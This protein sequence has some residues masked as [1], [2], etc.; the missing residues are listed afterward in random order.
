MRRKLLATAYPP[1]QKRDKSQVVSPGIDAAS[2]VGEA[3]E[4]GGM[5]REELTAGV[6]AGGGRAKAGEDASKAGQGT[7][8][9]ATGANAGAGGISAGKGRS[10]R[11]GGLEDLAGALEA[12]VRLIARY[13]TET[14]WKKQEHEL[15]NVPTIMRVCPSTP[16]QTHRP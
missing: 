13:R 14:P 3:R 10:F 8:N 2:R 15:A 12:A 5:T 4:G 6:R 16:S 9:S 11:L 1:P 7:M